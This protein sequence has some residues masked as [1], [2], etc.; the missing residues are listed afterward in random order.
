MGAGARG[1]GARRGRPLTITLRTAVILCTAWLVTSPYTLSWYD[2]IAWVPLALMV[3]N[4]LDWLMTLRGAALSV[5]YVTGRTVG[6]SDPMLFLGST[7]VRDT[8]CTAVQWF[9]LA[10]I[11]HWFWTTARS[12]PTPSFVA[13]PAG[14]RGAAVRPLTR[15]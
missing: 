15:P 1:D 11:V 5:A 7:I 3:P 2:L 6:F 8:L 9:V 14:A 10:A 12:W 13:G 4:R